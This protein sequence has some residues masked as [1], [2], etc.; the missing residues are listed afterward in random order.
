MSVR[1]FWLTN[2]EGTKFSLMPHANF[3]YEPEGLGYGVSLSTTKLGNTD[4]ILSESYNLGTFSGDL[5]F[6]DNE[7]GDKY[8]RYQE[9]MQFLAKRPI[10]LHYLPPNTSDA[11]FCSV[12]VISL[13]KTEVNW[14]DNVLHCPIE[15]YRQSMWFTER[16][17][18]L[19]VTTDVTDGKKYLL[20]RPY[21]YGV[22]SLS[23]ISIY[24]NGMVDTPLLLEVEGAV[25]D[26]TF[27]LYDEE[28]NKYGACKILGSYDY[29]RINSNEINEEIYLE[30]GGSVIPNAVNYQDLTVGSPQQVYVT[31]LRAKPG[32]STLVFIGDENFG[33]IV[34][35]TWRN[36]YVSI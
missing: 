25:V 31:F 15:L 4:I 27:E 33:G 36:A 6:M 1:E 12:R 13:E 35:V 34:H 29:V 3:L 28:A 17:N 24:N 32:K 19:D 7:L 18:V 20:D 9:F 5:L 22:K 30:R 14:E 11:Y 10:E 21:A 2:S 26:P 16:A 23:N 8:Q